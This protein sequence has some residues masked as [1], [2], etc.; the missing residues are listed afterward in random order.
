MSD[1]KTEE[2][3]HK[4]LE[5][6]R[7]DGQLPQRKNVLE[8]VLL[9]LGT[10]AIVALMAHVAQLC[11]G[12]FDAAL[13]GVNTGLTE[14]AAGVQRAVIPAVGFMLAIAGGLGAIIL[15]VSLQLTGFNAS[16]KPLEPNLSK[17]NPVNG[18]KQMFSIAILY[19]F[20][21][22]IIYFTV[23]TITLW[24]L[25]RSSL[26]DAIEAADCGLFCLAALFPPIFLKAAAILLFTLI[27]MAV[28]DYRIQDKLWRKQLKM[29]HEDIKREHKSSEGDPRIKG[30]RKSLAQADAHMPMM[31]DV[32]HVVHSQGVMVALVYKH[33]HIPFLAA[34][35]QGNTV[36]KL[37][38]KYRSLGAKCVNLPKVAREFYGMAPPGSYLRPQAAKGMAQVL[39]ATGEM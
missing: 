35:T 5:Q 29:S 17:L 9:T 10:C 28:I 13:A 39:R 14:G 12:I 38:R 4:R 20:V 34:K 37:V 16:M 8:A 30:A 3:T 18:L 27:I 24:V 7:R 2:P 32:T 31:R 19:N 1:D 6:A 15:F 36:P 33:G 21:R 22:L 23:A 11:A 26:A 25:V